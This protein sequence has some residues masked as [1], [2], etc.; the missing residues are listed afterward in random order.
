[1]T[2]TTATPSGGRLDDVV[3]TSHFGDNRLSTALLLA[4]ARLGGG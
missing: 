2:R 3:R 1:M 4:G